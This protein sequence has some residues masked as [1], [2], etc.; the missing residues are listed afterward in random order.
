MLPQAVGKSP[1]ASIITF[2]QDSPWGV[3]DCECYEKVCKYAPERTYSKH[4]FHAHYGV[5]ADFLS[6]QDILSM[7]LVN[8]VYTC[9]ISWLWVASLCT[10]QSSKGWLDI[11]DSKIL[12]FYFQVI[13][14][15][16][17][18]NLVLVIL[19]RCLFYFLYL[20]FKAIL[21]WICFKMW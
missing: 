11:A 19:L 9:Q 13:C 7:K 14:C 20:L 8:K 18:E 15:F 6:T 12:N 2:S 17:A 16:L 21:H 1:V 10:C 5:Q 4:R 3:W